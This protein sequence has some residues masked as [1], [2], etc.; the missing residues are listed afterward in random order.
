[1]SARAN[2]S[3]GIVLI[4]L[5]DLRQEVLVLVFSIDKL[6]ACER[7]AISILDSRG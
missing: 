6:D 2:T 1:M 7:R 5:L 4:L 3:L